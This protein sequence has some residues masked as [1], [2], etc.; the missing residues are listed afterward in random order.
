MNKKKIILTAGVVLVLAVAGFWIFGKKNAQGKVDFVTEKVTRGNISNSITATGTIEPVTEVEVGTQ[1]SGIIDKIYI[2]YNSVVKQGEVIAEMDKVTLLSDLQSAQA[3]Y[4]G[5][6][7]EYDYQKKLYTRNKALHEKQLISETDYEQSVYDYE[8]AKSTYE[9]TQAALAKAERNLSYATIT[10]PING[11]VTSKDVEEGQTVASGFETPTLFTIAA[12]L[13]KMQVVA[14]VDEADIAGIKDSARV[15][16]TVDAYPDDVFEGKVYQIRLGSVNSSSS[17]STSTSSETVVTYEVVITADNPDLKLKP[18][19]TANVT[20][21]TDTRDNVITVPNKALRFTPEKQLVGNKT[22]T[23]CEGAHKVWTMDANGFTAHPV[24]IGLSD[25]SHTEILEGLS[26][27]T[28]IVTETVLKGFE[29]NANAD[30]MAGGERSPFMPGPPGGDKKKQKKGDTLMKKTVI[31]LQNIKRNFQVGDETVHALRGV[32]F[33]IQ[34][35]EFVTIMGTSGSGKST[36]LNTLGCLDTPTSGEYL[37]D[38]V[39]VR[40]M[41][42]PQRAV[43]RNRKIGFVFQNY[44]LLPKTTAVE[45]VELPLM[46]NSSV[47]AAERRRRAIEALTAVGLADRLE[48]KSNQMSGG[49]MQRVAIARALVNNPAVILAD[50]ATGNLDTRTSF[51][52]LVLFQKLHQEG[53]TI[54]FVTHNPELSQYS[55]RNIRLRDGHVI[56]DVTNPHI[57][58]AAEALAA[59][60]KNDDD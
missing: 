4:N 15:T 32:S 39:S 55:S 1:V 21:Y 54:I 23:D 13:T 46:Y 43:L 26:E 49:Q 3:T 11:I 42:K 45:N 34:E 27:G 6:K 22:I 7:A 31:E 24:K 9:Q 28:P 40:T 41:S 35:G 18:R 57:L 58:S 29:N 30:E 50:E 52:I 56:E 17:S 38:G 10:S 12:D 19:L 8:R 14:D 37:L 53:R 60:P 36:L 2:D 5:A 16:F 47:S 51:E 33:S 59:L 48:H 20:I 25:G 44:N